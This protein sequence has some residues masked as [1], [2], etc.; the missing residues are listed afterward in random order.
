MK[1][2][3]KNLAV[4]VGL[5]AFCNTDLLANEPVI[6]VKSKSEYSAPIIVIRSK[7]DFKKSIS[8][9]LNAIIASYTRRSANIYSA[10]L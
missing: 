8:L 1:T 9:K 5:S 7:Y 3:I 4:A 10:F 2:F 6:T